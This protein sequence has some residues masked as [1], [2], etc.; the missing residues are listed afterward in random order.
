MPITETSPLASAL[1]WWSILRRHLLLCI[2]VAVGAFA[3]ACVFIARMPNIYKAE[4]RILVNP[5]RISDKYVSSAVSMD[6]TERL[7]TLSQQV[8][9]STRLEAIIEDLHLFPS[10][11]KQLGRDQLIEKMRQHITIDL[12]QNSDG[13]SSF[14]LSYTGESA[15][16]VADVTNR[17]A[18]SFIA[19][20]LRDRAAEAQGTTSFLADELAQ[21]KS[22][23]DSLEEQLRVYKLQHL[24]ELPDQMQANLQTLSRLQIQ[25]QANVEAQSRLDH[26]AF[27]AQ[28]DS[29]AAIGPSA[30]PTV[31]QRQQLVQ[32]ASQARHD[33][34]ELRGRY[35]DE[36]PAVVAKQEQIRA[37]DAQIE[38]T[39]IATSNSPVPTRAV[40]NSN[41]P[42]LQLIAHDRTRLTAERHDIEGQIRS[43]QGRVDS[44]PVREQEISQLL[45]DYDTAKEHYKSL[46]EKTYSAQMSAELEHQ[47]QGGTFTMLDAA[48]VPDLPIGPNRGGLFGGFAFLAIAL[49][50]GAGVLRE[51]MDGTVKSERSFS[52]LAP[53][54]PLLGVVPQLTFSTPKLIP[55]FD[56]RE[57]T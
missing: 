32:R 47:Q 22:K 17:L 35:T 48:R 8:M 33:L 29:N 34:A 21:S 39:P 15:K 12:K 27:L 31:S 19:W 54:I 37:L 5:Q 18:A 53:R 30:A 46:L 24:G 51:L 36:F 44:S 38:S 41:D 20:N 1:E 52:E 2:L 10:L 56:L 6:S 26:E 55:A 42:Q 11:R 23:L 25:L 3:T 13:P 9:S 14:T 49:G 16:E 40:S 57:T 4:T 45:R 50:I 43:Y 28:V 7:N